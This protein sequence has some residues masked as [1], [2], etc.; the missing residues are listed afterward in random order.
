LKRQA[1]KKTTS[2]LPFSATQ[3]PHNPKSSFFTN[4][5]IQD[6]GMA[7]SVHGSEFLKVENLGKVRNPLPIFFLPCH[8]EPKPSFCSCMSFISWWGALGG[9]GTKHHLGE[10]NCG[11]LE[12]DLCC[13]WCCSARLAVASGY[14]PGE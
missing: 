4:S 13:C 14:S 12:A 7:N 11:R 1:S 5:S 3:K 9:E 6:L 8:F 2:S 10:M